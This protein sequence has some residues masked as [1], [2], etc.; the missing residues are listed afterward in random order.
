[1]DPSKTYYNPEL[2]S[3]PAPQLTRK[4][5]RAMSPEQVVEADTAGQFA[6]LKSQG[7][8][9]VEAERRGERWATREEAQEALQAAAADRN[10]IKTEQRAQARAEGV[11]VR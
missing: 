9:P 6:V 10:R 5:L 8:D 7:R 1:M 11:D 2:A 3:R 4:E